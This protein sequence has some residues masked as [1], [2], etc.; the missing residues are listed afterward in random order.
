MPTKS[1]TTLFLRRLISQRLRASEVPLIS[2]ETLKRKYS[3]FGRM[4]LLHANNSPD[5]NYQSSRTS[6]VDST[7]N[8]LSRL[9]APVSNP[10]AT[11]KSSKAHI[12][13]R[14]PLMPSPT[15]AL[16]PKEEAQVVAALHPQPQAQALPFPTV[17]A[18][19]LLVCRSSEAF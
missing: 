4:E 6:V 8:Q 10:S 3:S 14:P 9:T 12:L 15:M 5:L 19:R 16:P 2:L 13:A 18:T 7:C 17:Q 1:P 11:A